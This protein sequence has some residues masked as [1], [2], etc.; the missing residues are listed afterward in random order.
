V[1][2]PDQVSGMSQDEADRL[3]AELDEAWFVVEAH[4]RERTARLTAGAA[5]PVPAVAVV[6]LAPPPVAQAVPYLPPAY[7][8]PPGAA[9]GP[10]AAQPWQPPTRPMTRREWRAAQRLTASHVPP[11]RR[12]ILTAASFALGVLI[13]QFVKAFVRGMVT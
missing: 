1:L 5:P 6:P 3:L 13:Y 10:W 11:K 9:P 2:H 8:P 12:P 7:G 4:L